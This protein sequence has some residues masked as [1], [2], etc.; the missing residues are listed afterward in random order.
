VQPPSP[1]PISNALRAFGDG[2]RRSMRG[3]EFIRIVGA[4]HRKDALRAMYHRNYSTLTLARSQENRT[5]NI[6]R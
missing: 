3:P 4:R 2:K 6:E 5:G 1:H